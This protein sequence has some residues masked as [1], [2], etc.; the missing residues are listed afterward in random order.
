MVQRGAPG[1]DPG[2]CSVGIPSDLP[3]GGRKSGN[4]V[5]FVSKSDLAVVKPC[6]LAAGHL[7]G[8]T[9]SSGGA[10]GLTTVVKRAKLA[11]GIQ[12]WSSGKPSQGVA[13]GA[14]L[15][16]FPLM[17]VEVPTALVDGGATGLPHREST[18]TRQGT[19][20]DGM[21][22]D[23]RL[24]EG[25]ANSRY[26]LTAREA[27]YHPPKHAKDIHSFACSWSTK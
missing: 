8:H 18:A 26:L 19:L 12:T 1:H 11:A 16:F 14:R 7:G 22:A 27:F 24:R 17:V 10:T 25:W 9:G 6:E 3:Y 2:P 21:R 20:T 4:A 15:L 5:G 23:Y 13:D